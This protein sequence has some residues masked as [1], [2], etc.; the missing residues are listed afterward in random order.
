MPSLVAF[1]ATVE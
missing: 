1:I